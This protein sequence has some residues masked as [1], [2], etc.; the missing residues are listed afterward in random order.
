MAH[1]TDGYVTSNGFRMHYVHT[2]GDKTALVLSHGITDDGLCWTRF[3]K[4]M[5]SEYDVI[6]PDARGHGLSESLPG[7]FT[8]EDQADDLAG[9]IQGLG[10]DRPLVGGHSM[11]GATSFYLAANHPDL[12]SLV[13]LEDPPFRATE[14]TPAQ[15]EQRGAT[16]HQQALARSQMSRDQ[17]I[18]DGRKEHP[19]WPDEEFEPWSLAKQRVRLE[20]AAVVRPPEGQTWR[21][22]LPKVQCPALLI[23]A[24]PELGGIVTPE[25]AAEAKSLLPSLQVVRLRGAGHNIRREAFDEYVTAVRQFLARS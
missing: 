15:R 1:W 23:T 19:N 22:A 24:D 21:Q 6:M 13:F 18:A 25:V 9:F 16:M 7:P 5:E 11:G 4:A 20:T 10:L 12:L 14:P 8:W 2:G 17:I 3:A